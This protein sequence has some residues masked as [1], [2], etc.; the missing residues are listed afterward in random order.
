[1]SNVHVFGVHKVTKHGKVNHDGKGQS[2]G[3]FQGELSFG[4]MHEAISC[5]IE[6]VSYFR[7]S[8]VTQVYT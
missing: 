4:R 5:A 6:N 2:N 3:Y 7:L 8:W 1:M